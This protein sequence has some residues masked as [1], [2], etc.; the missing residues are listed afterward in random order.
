MTLIKGLTRKQTEVLT[1]LSRDRLA[2][3]SKCGIVTPEKFGS[4][5]RS[6]LV[7]SFRQ[8][9]ELREIGKLRQE[10]SLQSIR[11][12]I[13]FL[14]SSNQDN[15]SIVA[16]TNKIAVINGVCYWV[17]SDLSNLNKIFITI[18]GKDSG[19]VYIADLMILPSPSETAKEII[20]IAKRS[21]DVIDFADFRYIADLA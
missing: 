7:Y 8:V 12:V 15:P 11:Q 18:S 5:S 20:D 17:A 4:G 6:A 9:L 14:Q 1:G 2:Y 10:T 13:K 21:S 19:Q 3:L 16:N